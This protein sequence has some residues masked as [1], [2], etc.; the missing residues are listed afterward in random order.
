MR[1]TA[2]SLPLTTVAALL[3]L[4]G[5]GCESPDPVREPPGEAPQSDAPVPASPSL[6]DLRTWLA[7]G[8]TVDVIVELTPRAASA[9][10]RL[11]GSTVVPVHDVPTWHAAAAVFVASHTDA[12]LALLHRYNNFPSLH[13][14]VPTLALLD[15][16]LA[17]PRVAAVFPNIAVS[18]SDLQANDVIGRATAN[19]ALLH[20][21][22]VGAGTSV[23][24]IDTGL[25]YTHADFGSC[26]AGTL[27]TAGCKV[28]AVAEFATAD[29][30]LDDHAQ[31]H[32]SNVAGIVVSVAPGAKV[33]GLDTFKD[34]GTAGEGSAILAALDWVI[35]NRARHNIVAVNMSLGDN[36]RY[37]AAC[38]G[39]Y[40]STP[41]G[42]VLAANV[43]V[44]AATG[45]SGH[46]TTMSSPAC[47][48][49][50]ISVGSV[51]DD[52]HYGLSFGAC[53]DASPLRDTIPCYSNGADFMTIL[54]P[55]TM[56]AAAGVNLSGT[57]MASPH[58]AGAFAVLRAQ[59]PSD[60]ITTIRDRMVS[61]GLE[62]TDVRAG[63]TPAGRT[64]RRLDLGAAILA[65]DCSYSLDMADI[66][67]PH[68]G[69]TYTVAVTTSPACTWSVLESASWL[70]ATAAS[71]PMQGSG[72]FTLRVAT[73][74]SG[75]ASRQATVVV[76]EATLTVGQVFDPAQVDGT[77][78]EANFYID[79]SGSPSTSAEVTA[80]LDVTLSF[81]ATPGDVASFCVK[82]TATAC[83]EGEF[84]DFTGEAM[85]WTLTGGTPGARAVYV[86]FMD[87]QYNVTTRSR[88]ILFDNAGPSGGKLTLKKRERTQLTLAATAFADLLP[89]DARVLRFQTGTTVAPP[90]SDDVGDGV[91][92]LTWP[93]AAGAMQPTFLHA[94]LTE[95]V[96]VAYTLCARDRLGN[97][98]PGSSVVTAP[99]ADLVAPRIATATV[100][101][102][103]KATKDLAVL[104]NATATDLNSAYGFQV[105][106]G[107]TKALCAA[108]DWRSLG[109]DMSH[110][111]IDG[112][113]GRRT[114]YVRVRDRALNASAMRAVRINYD[115]TPPTPG[116]VRLT[117]GEA[118]VTLAFSR[119]VDRHSGIAGYKVAWAKD[120]P[121]ATCDD[122]TLLADGFIPAPGPYT[123]S[124]LTNFDTMGYRVCAIDR[125]G[126]V[127]E[128]SLSG[129]VVVKPDVTAPVGRFTLAGDYTAAGIAY[130][131][132]VGG[133]S[134]SL[135]LQSA[136]VDAS[137]ITDMCISTTSVCTA[138]VPYE[139]THTWAVPVTSGTLK[140]WITYR[141]AW[142]NES[143]PVARSAFVDG[144]FP[145]IGSIVWS[146]SGSKVTI[147]PRSATDNGGAG[148]KTLKTVFKFNA[149]APATDCSDG[150]VLANSRTG[151]GSHTVSRGVYVYRVC[152]EDNVGNTGSA[153]LLQLTV[154]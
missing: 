119:W 101:S 44:V 154:N 110:T 56:I 60:A 123:H 61:T 142:N 128:T 37:S 106:I 97:W 64:H 115:I 111:L 82:S 41:I 104:V 136:P 149:G 71:T 11:G 102:G 84:A 13:V 31:R 39:T 72:T 2:R 152:S 26:S 55:G 103:A 126:H 151:A 7:D 53:S 62:I 4:G 20:G 65:A 117:G 32:G 30:A 57:S 94:G 77:A 80:D 118:Q 148:L 12:G 105:C 139:A 73:Q 21:T 78:P 83:A 70:T 86:T 19:G 75:G 150:T 132:K 113:S 127:S 8:E 138:W 18:P 153:G 28:A 3:A 27:N 54:A 99:S 96:P 141:D 33:I 58:V 34:R 121:P 50:V 122:G 92:E 129:T 29:G 40:F 45:N 23:A 48:P 107:N 88:T 16:L 24:V 112:L 114:V 125:V 76:G 51:Y 140:V 116:R 36:G 68:T 146:A 98:S 63:V 91:G 93:V 66:D 100:N 90:C 49:G 143:V 120:V 147:T 137:A 42:Q 59:R 79:A 35:D 6:D 10:T 1:R 134:P 145:T 17:D 95:D 5:V 9:A 81:E 67:A 89:I 69:D 46:V 74:F 47:V 144:A 131:R 108:S 130:V 43:A 15:R 87:A 124:G 22:H 52:A 135:T 85:P 25:D 109:T 14:E 133:S 38:G